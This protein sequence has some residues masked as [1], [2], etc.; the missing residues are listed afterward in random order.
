VCF[1]LPVHP[2]SKFS[3]LFDQA[4]T[5][6]F[7]VFN[8]FIEMKKSHIILKKERESNFAKHLF[9]VIQS[10]S[11]AL[12]AAICPF[13]AEPICRIL[14][15]LDSCVE[16]NNLHFAPCAQPISQVFLAIGVRV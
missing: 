9:V 12:H 14:C 3:A 16:P 10:S 8:Q 5:I 15:R 4:I 2:I 7:F 1:A 11:H 13:G 6:L